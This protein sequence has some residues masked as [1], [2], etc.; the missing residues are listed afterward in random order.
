MQPSNNCNS[1]TI[2]VLETK[3]RFSSLLFSVI[4]LKISWIVA[5]RKIINCSNTTISIINRPSE[6]Q[7][8][9]VS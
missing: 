9:L 5:L 7:E 4:P 3:S 2:N 1:N 6:G 8:F